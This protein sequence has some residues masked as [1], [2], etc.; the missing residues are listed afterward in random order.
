[1]KPHNFGPPVH[2]QLHHFADASE[3]YGTITYLRLQNEPGDVHV[4]FPLGIVTPLKPVTIPHLE[5]TAVLA[6]LVDKMVNAVLQLQLEESCFWT[7][8]STVF[9]YINNEN[10]RLRTLVSVLTE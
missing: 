9:K 6:D 10:K 3:G 2:T 1:M 7:D 4:S 5:L 8:S